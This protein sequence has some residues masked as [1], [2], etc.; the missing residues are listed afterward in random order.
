[1]TEAE[2][3]VCTDPDLM[4]KQV[5]RQASNRKRRLFACACYRHVPQLVQDEQC[6]NAVAVSE[7]YAD[8]LA[9]KAELCTVLNAARWRF[10]WHVPSP[11]PTARYAEEARRVAARMAKE[12]FS[13]RLYQSSVVRDLFGNH[14][15]RVTAV[16][17]WLTWNESTATKIAQAIYT[18]RAFDRLP[19]LADALEEAGCHD[20]DILAHCR[21]PGEH[22]R[23]CWLVD[24]LVGKE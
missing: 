17:S 9:S 16:P 8:G 20:P 4:I 23:G 5:G 13:E 11:L 3:L 7:R 15:R 2:W 19:V 22:V 24:L 18:D 1:M 14:F 12:G 6:L 21:Q 10:P